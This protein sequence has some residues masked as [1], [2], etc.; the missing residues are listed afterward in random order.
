MDGDSTVLRKRWI[1]MNECRWVKPFVVLVFLFQIQEMAQSDAVVE[2]VPVPPIN[3]TTLDGS[4]VSISAEEDHEITVVC[5]LSSS[6][7]PC[8]RRNCWLG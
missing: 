5:F 3:V 2:S 1:S 4:T 7:E 8:P 6:H